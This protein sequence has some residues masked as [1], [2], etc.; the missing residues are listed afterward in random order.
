M[1]RFFI[2]YKKMLVVES[3]LCTGCHRC[4]MWCSF[5]KFNEI[6]PTR[7]NIYIVRREPAIDVPIICTQCGLCIEVCSVGAL[8]RNLSG[9]VVDSTICS[10][11]GK[12]VLVC[13]YGVIRIDEDTNV[14]AKCDLCGGDPVCVKHCEQGALRYEDSKKVATKRREQCAIAISKYTKAW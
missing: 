7:S 8:K 14:A 5:T 9:V 2:V 6:N 3:E 12:C 13:P 4:E 10:G 1:W 11:C